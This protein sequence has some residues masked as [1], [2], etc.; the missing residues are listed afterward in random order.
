[1]FLQ[2]RAA[3]WARVKAPSLGN[4]SVTSSHT[5]G[6]V[7]QHRDLVN[8]ATARSAGDKSAL[9]VCDCNSTQDSAA[10]TFIREAGWIDTANRLHTAGAT[11]DQDITAAAATV[12]HRI[13]YVF[14]KSREGLKALSSK[15]FM[16]QRAPS[17]LTTSG[18]LWPSDHW[19]VIDTL[20]FT[21]G[22]LPHTG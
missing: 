4:V 14:L 5:S 17:A 9:L 7:R 20:G 3:V 8:W 13:D 18:W 11:S 16:N 2:S 19:G 22:G 1:M 15:R 10:Q 21:S 6:T 12:D